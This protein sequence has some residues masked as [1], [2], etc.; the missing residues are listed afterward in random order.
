MAKKGTTTAQLL[1]FLCCQQTC[2][3]CFNC[4]HEVSNLRT[5]K[6]TRQD[7]Q[8][9][10]FTESSRS[11]YVSFEN[12]LPSQFQDP[13]SLLVKLDLNLTSFPCQTL[14][15]PKCKINSFVSGILPESRTFAVLLPEDKN[16]YSPS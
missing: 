3:H 11:T 6:V 5:T 8:R 15:F 9:L 7:T 12:N 16:I 14:N 10:P 1:S 13:Y 2:C 4:I